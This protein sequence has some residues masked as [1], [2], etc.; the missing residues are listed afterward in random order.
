MK[1][2]SGSKSS[3]ENGG[4]A[5]MVRNSNKDE[6]EGSC[7]EELWRYSNNE[8][9]CNNKGYNEEIEDHEDKGRIGNSRRGGRGRKGR[10]EG[11]GRKRR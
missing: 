3:C 1:T 11:Q 6:S 10:A 5:V 7:S 8:S 9:G 2:R 4:H